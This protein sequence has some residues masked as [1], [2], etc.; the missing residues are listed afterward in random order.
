MRNFLLIV[1][2]LLMG[3]SLSGQQFYFKQIKNPAKKRN[4][5]IAP[6][7]EGGF[8]V[9]NELD[10]DST[11]FQLIK[12]DT[13]GTLV[14]HHSYSDSLL[15]EFN[16]LH[17]VVDQTNTMYVAGLS[18][19]KSSSLPQLTVLI[20]SEDQ[21]VLRA[22]H[23]NTH[24]ALLKITDTKINTSGDIYLSTYESGAGTAANASSLYKFSNAGNLL[25]R[26]TYEDYSNFDKLALVEGGNILTV[27]FADTFP[28]LSKFS[29]NGSLIWSK[30]IPQK[31]EMVSNPLFAFN[32]YY[33]VGSSNELKDTSGLPFSRRLI[34]FDTDGNI[35]NTGERFTGKGEG[36]LL[37]NLNTLLYYQYDSLKEDTINFLSFTLLG[38][39]GVVNAQFA[40][41]DF[42]DS[43]D[44]ALTTPPIAVLNT[45]GG[46]NLDLVI[47]NQAAINDST[48]LHYVG[49]TATPAFLLGMGCNSIS[50][51]QKDTVIETLPT[52]EDTLL[53]QNIMTN[54]FKTDTFQF[55]DVQTMDTTICEISPQ[56]GEEP[57]FHCTGE[58]LKVFDKRRGVTLTITRDTT[59]INEQFNFCG[60]TITYSTKYVFNTPDPNLTIPKAFT[61]NGD[62]VNDKFGIV[63]DSTVFSTLSFSTFQLSIFNRWG[64]KV[65]ATENVN[66]RWDGTYKGKPVP[67]GVYV[68]TLL[69][70]GKMNGKCDFS[71]SLQ[72]DVTLIR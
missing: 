2:G 24:S 69:Y 25:W 54:L 57:S 27:G 53:V 60:S 12:Y 1:I 65:F 51:I 71:S 56:S 28:L 32:S 19:D 31:Y 10:S 66:E 3:L 62:N 39:T 55:S 59:V 35:T 14:W 58:V 23:Y 5:G 64:E 61:P 9:M 15:K 46:D 41:D 48:F 33:I 18:T 22:F 26:R 52:K 68:Y 42:D 45:N 7:A 17:L 67:V 13:C 20:I 34:Q 36:T 72:G 47:T 8:L 21:T 38:E 63:A 16:D 49:K 6:T 11:F 44:Y 4:V 50:Y 70:E 37:G 40:Y 43:L 30:V 29:A